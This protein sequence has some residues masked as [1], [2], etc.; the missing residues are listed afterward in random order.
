MIGDDMGLRAYEVMSIF[1]SLCTLKIT[2]KSASLKYHEVKAPGDMLI[3]EYGPYEDTAI[4]LFCRTFNNINANSLSF[5][6][7]L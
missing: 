1:F 6:S 3:G 2:I 7:F 4:R 5:F